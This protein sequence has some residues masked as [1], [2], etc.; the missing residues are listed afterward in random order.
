MMAF[1]II[2]TLSLCIVFTWVL[3]VGFTWLFMFPMP[4]GGYAEPFV[5]KAMSFA[6]AF[7]HGSGAWMFYF[8]VMGG[9]FMPIAAAILSYWIKTR[10]VLKVDALAITVSAFI[11][12]FIWCLFLALLET[13]IG[14]W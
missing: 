13:V 2:K 1:S 14:Q 3:S 9:I 12:A 11:P 10:E 8:L 6:E 7:E 4:F 5:G